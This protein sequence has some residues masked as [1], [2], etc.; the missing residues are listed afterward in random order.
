MEPTNFSNPSDEWFLSPGETPIASPYEKQIS[1][2]FS[3]SMSPNHA[4]SSYLADLNALAESLNPGMPDSQPPNQVNYQ[5]IVNSDNE[6]GENTLTQTLGRHEKSTQSKNVVSMRTKKIQTS[7]DKKKRNV[8]DKRIYDDEELNDVNEHQL[9][10]S[11]KNKYM[12]HLCK[13]GQFDGHAHPANYSA[14][15]LSKELSLNF[16]AINISLEESKE[17]DSSNQ[18]SVNENETSNESEMGNEGKSTIGIETDSMIGNEAGH[19]TNNI[20]ENLDPSQTEN[21]ENSLDTEP[22]TNLNET[23]KRKKLCVKA[24]DELKQWLLLNSYDPYPSLSLKQY[25]AQKYGVE[26]PVINNFFTNER[27]RFLNRTRSHKQN[28]SP[29]MLIREM[30]YIPSDGILRTVRIAS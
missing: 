28:P 9:L 30:V 2:C 13:Y 25:F 8:M 5:F 15:S 16:P 19:T 29:C 18:D 20:I 27:K 3:P 12:M 1:A 4:L 17:K 10:S 22:T 14:L 23:R 11:Q 6:M 21:N 24:R 7:N 26:L